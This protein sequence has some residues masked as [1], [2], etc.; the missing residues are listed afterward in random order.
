MSFHHLVILASDAAINFRRLL[1]QFS[2]RVGGATG[3]ARSGP[4]SL[5][6]SLGRG[7]LGVSAGPDE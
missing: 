7:A 6:G 3:S 4:P 1:L 2:V 5:R